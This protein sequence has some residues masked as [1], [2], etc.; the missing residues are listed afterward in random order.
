MSS[1]NLVSPLAFTQSGM[2]GSLKNRFVGTS[3]EGKVHAKTGSISRTNTLSG[4]V[5]LESG[6]VVTF[7]VQANH[8]TQRTAAIL[9]QIDS[10]VVE[11]AKGR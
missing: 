8:H 3:I 10:V 7:S 1:S 9:A 2:R 6:K 4:W 5:E 11:M